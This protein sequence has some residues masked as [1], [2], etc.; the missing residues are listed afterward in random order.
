MTALRRMVLAAAGLLF[1][2]WLIVNYG[3]IT[4]DEEGFI[5]FVLGGLFAVLILF[6]PKAK[7][8]GGRPES[9]APAGG[10]GGF[11]LLAAG[12]GGALLSM[13]GLVFDVHQFE[14]LGMVLILY[15]CLRWALPARYGRD[16]LLALFLLYWIHPIP[17]QIFGKFQLAMQWMSIKG[18]EWLLHCLNVRVWADGFVLR[19]GLRAFGIPEVCSGMRTSVTVLLCTLGVGMLFRLRWYEIGVF[20]VLGVIQVLVLNILRIAFTVIWASRM[21]PEW[22]DTFLHDTLGIFLLVSILLVQLEVSWWKY[23]TAKRRRHREG[24]ASGELEHIDRA[25]PIPKAW[26]F[27]H[28]YGLP[29]LGV[30][31]VALGIAFAVYKRRPHHRAV[32][33]SEVVDGL[34]EYDLEAAERGIDAALALEG[35]D[36]DMLIK[37]ARIL[38]M[39]EKHEEALRLI[40]AA[41]GPKDTFETALKSHALVALERPREAEALLDTLPER[42]Q[43][44]PG[45]AVIRAE[46]AALLDEPLTAGENVVLAADSH[47]A[48]ERVRR[49]YPYLAGREQWAAIVESDR[50]LPYKDFENAFIA[51]TANLRTRHLPG[52]ARV[53]RNVLQAWPLDPRL[54]G[55]LSVLAQ[56]QPNEGWEA[57]FAENLKVN[58][59]R[60]NAEALSGVID[61]CF[62]MTRPDLAWQVYTALRRRAPRDPALFMAPAQ[63]GGA[64]FTFRRHAVGLEATSPAETIDLGPLFVQLRTGPPFAACWNRIPLAGE[65]AAADP[66]RAREVF[67]EEAIAEFEA[68][69][70]AGTLSPRMEMAYPV[71]LAMHG[72]YDRAHARLDTIAER[73]PERER[74][75]VFQHAVFYDEEER[76]EESY[77]A[78]VRYRTLAD[79]PNLT[80]DLLTANALMNLNLGVCAMDVVETAREIFPGAPKLDLAMAS[81]WDTFG[82]KEEALFLIENS[83]VPGKAR[84]SAQLLYDT[85]RYAEARR[86]SGALGIRLVEK[87]IPTQRVLPRPAERVLTR[88]WP[89]P[90]D[91]AGMDEE[92][93]RYAAMAEASRSPF[94]RELHGLQAQWFRQRGEGAISDPE[95]WSAIGRDML[96]KAGALNRLSTL[97][98]W[99]RHYD[100]ALAPARQALQYLP[101]SPMLY[102]VLIALT[103]GD[104][105]VVRAGRETCPGDPEIWLADLVLRHREGGP[106][107]WALEAVEAARGRY[108]PGAMVRAGD[109][110]LRAGM[111]DAAAAAARDAIKRGRGLVSAYVL[112]LRCALETGNRDWAL[113]CALNGV[114]NALDPT[115]FYKTVVALKAAGGSSDA[116]MVSAL[117]FLRERFPDETQWSERLGQ[118]Y[119]EKR[120]A[121]RVLSVLQPAIEGDI[122]K[123][124]VKSIMM[125][126]EAARLEGDMTR[127]IGILERAHEMYPEKATILNNLIYYLAQNPATLPRARALLPELL[128]QGGEVFPVLDTAAVVYLRSGQLER[129][130]GFMQRALAVIDE[131]SYGVAE[132]RLNAAE[133]LYRLGRYESARQAVEAV[134]KTPNRSYEVDRRARALQEQIEEKLLR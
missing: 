65:L 93:L 89:P 45:V 59:P 48:L 123:V 33:I 40:R 103:E 11:R 37:K 78:L 118:I 18:A 76:W 94:F 132:A 124:R 12:A 55:G 128:E 56:A 77:E 53:M 99:Q 121:G 101:E 38:I 57:H 41:G 73:Y 107:A 63:F 96:E 102:R 6:R 15:A 16:I 39:R 36:R 86:L 46:C 30:A 51:L 66:D 100:R 114:E 90:R 44:L 24:I 133:I 13:T 84:I 67:L 116:D 70:A 95:R 14:W 83:D 91:E 69:D 125:A 81:V 105:E 80:A 104:P 92:V 5:R 131:R 71:A 126:A 62:R 74:D 47:L 34:M 22:A 119:F 112:G 29:L 75:V 28:H 21:P 68:R 106:G 130:A 1:L 35:G 43:R 129:A 52:A 88:Q 8:T 9:G 110:L 19:I 109:F 115:P 49:L 26:R 23:R 108:A 72:R 42:D 31:I 134:R 97:L 60:L 50:D 3:R 27:V 64:W 4:A 58:L 85:G 25:K 127:A 10:R 82:Y 111:S 20:L 98:A 122:K 54:L 117:E 2:V 87:D 113:A 79:A 7:P 61:D 17:G 32:M 120:D